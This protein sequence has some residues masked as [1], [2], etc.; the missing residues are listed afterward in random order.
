M[1]TPII[2]TADL[3]GAVEALDVI[4]EG[5]R[6]AQKAGIECTTEQLA[7]IALT[8]GDSPAARARQAIVLAAAL[9]RLAAR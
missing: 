3:A 8:D 5:L 4:L 6:C 9:Q 2:T 1:S 7:M